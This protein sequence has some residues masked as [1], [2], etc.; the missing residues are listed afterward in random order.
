[1]NPLRTSRT[2]R[3][4]TLIELLLVVI[5]IAL[6]ISILL[7][8]LANARRSARVMICASQMRQIAIGQQAY[9]SDA[10]G[11]VPNLHA[12]PGKWKSEYTDLTNTATTRPMDV[13][14]DQAV[15]YARKLTGYGSSEIPR[16]RTRVFNRNY[17]HLMLI[18]GGYFGTDKAIELG[19]VCPEET[20]PLEWR[21]RKPSEMPAIISTGSVPVE[22]RST[23]NMLPFW[24]TYQAVPCSFSNDRRIGNVYTFAQSLSL[25]HQF[26]VG[27]GPLGQRRFDQINFPA[28][29][30]AFF[31]IYDRHFAK[32]HRRMWWH[33]D[34]IAKQP[35][36][37][38]DGS[39]RVLITKNSQ[40]GFKP[41]T[42]EPATP[43]TYQF[44]PME[45]PKFEAPSRVG[46]GTAAQ[47]MKGYFRWTRDGLRG[48]DY[49]S[50]K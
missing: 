29:K 23:A 2:P 7:P 39:V 17:W 38:F 50:D 11:R 30:V 49:I 31:D 47:T 20:L 40:P 42:P 21:K 6:L 28:Q 32:N 35:L 16:M 1:M 10:S 37:F 34:E 19:V 44:R 18:Y 8:A 45:D 24:M 36:A 46:N 12:V 27:G 25:H 4:F 9:Q 14:A 3:A 33:A 26:Y 15:E 41:N 13:A 43:E 5:I 22:Y 48:F